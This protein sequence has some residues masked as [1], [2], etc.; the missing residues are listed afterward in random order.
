M[1]ILVWFDG[2][3][4]LVDTNCL[5]PTYVGNYMSLQWWVINEVSFVPVILCSP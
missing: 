1:V 4:S 2:R 3:T 5:V